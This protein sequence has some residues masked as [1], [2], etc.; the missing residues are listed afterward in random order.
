MSYLI[1]PVS[2]N[3]SMRLLKMMGIDERENSIDLQ[4]KII[5]EWRDQRITFNNL[6]KDSFFNA[7]TEDEM[8][9]IWLPILIYTNTDQKETTRL[10]WVSE[11][12]TSVIVSRDGNFTR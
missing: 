11:W 12:S 5:L 10:G 7:L 1:V 8:R 4:F 9:T 2:I 3:V 6:K